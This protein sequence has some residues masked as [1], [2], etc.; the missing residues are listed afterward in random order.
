MQYTHRN[1][2]T[3]PPAE[4]GYFWFR[5]QIIRPGQ[6]R[7]TRHLLCGLVFGSGELVIRPSSKVVSVQDCHGQWW[8]PVTPPWE[9]GQ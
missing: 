4:R 5:G 7:G 6:V 8:G 9:E 3:E 1:G 2:E